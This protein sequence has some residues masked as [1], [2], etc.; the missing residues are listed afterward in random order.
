LDTAFAATFSSR[1]RTTCNDSERSGPEAAE[2]ESLDG[3][4][5]VAHAGVVGPE[6]PHH[7]SA[8]RWGDAGVQRSFV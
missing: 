5:E 1:S 2:S 4:D 8:A 3:A 7:W 6:A